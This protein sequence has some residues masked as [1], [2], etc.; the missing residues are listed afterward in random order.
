M[1]L[2]PDLGALPGWQSPGYGPRRIEQ[3]LRI[4]GVDRSAIRETMQRNFAPRRANDE[5]ALERFY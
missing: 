1:H 2:R 5:S 4:K 3:E